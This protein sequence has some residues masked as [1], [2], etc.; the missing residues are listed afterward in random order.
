VEARFITS[1]TGFWQ[2]RSASELVFE[3]ESAYHGS[4]K[5]DDT[6]KFTGRFKLAD[7]VADIQVSRIH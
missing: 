2:R 1:L 4:T 7:P 5:K 3:S 6:F